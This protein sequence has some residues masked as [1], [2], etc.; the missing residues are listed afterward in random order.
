MPVA[1][2]FL[3]KYDGSVDEWHALT[4]QQQELVRKADEEEKQKNAQQK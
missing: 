1:N 3:N 4:K 2:I